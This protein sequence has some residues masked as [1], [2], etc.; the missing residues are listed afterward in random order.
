MKYSKFKDF[1][2][3]NMP[4]NPIPGL[5]Q[6]KGELRMHIL[7]NPE[8]PEEKAELINKYSLLPNV[9]PIDPQTIHLHQYAH[10]LNSSQIMC[11]NFFR[12]M[13]EAF[14]GTMYKPKKCLLNLFGMEIDKEIEPNE[15]I[16]NFE[17]IDGSNENTNFDFFLKSNNIEVY[18]EIKYT[19]DKFAESSSAKNPHEQFLCVYKPMI[20]K[21]KEI[22]VDGAISETDFNTMYYQLARNAMRATSPDKH[23][24]FICP[25]EHEEL[26]QQFKEF[27]D[28]CLT[29]E[30]KNRVKLITWEDIV[31]DAYRLGINIEDFNNRYLAFMP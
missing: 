23:V 24:F 14:D 28:K 29:D 31:Q 21:A 30:G 7:G 26:I 22:F 20:E 5:W 13:M 10:H 18:C 17:Y 4:K 12:P 11:Y 3:E 9:P 27:S 2:L 6:H 16:C 19:E 15:A 25:K 8:T 1:V